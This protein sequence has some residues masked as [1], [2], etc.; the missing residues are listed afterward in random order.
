MM[1]YDKC[2]KRESE[3]VGRSMLFTFTRVFYVMQ[4]YINCYS[5]VV[6]PYKT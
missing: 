1:S 3:N 5:S 2:I 6:T 4:A